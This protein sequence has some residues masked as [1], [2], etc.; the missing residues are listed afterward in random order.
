MKIKKTIIKNNNNKKIIYAYVLHL[1]TERSSH[2]RW[3]II[4]DVFKNYLK[5]TCAGV[6]F[7]IKLLTAFLILLLLTFSISLFFFLCSPLGIQNN[8]FSF[9][10]DIFSKNDQENA[11]DEI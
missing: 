2:R 11:K 9:C 7:L 3:S 8:V 5:F 4:R 6:S 1:L 10:T